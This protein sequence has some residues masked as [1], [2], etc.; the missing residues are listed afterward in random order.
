M[1]CQT[2]PSTI[3]EMADKL[4]AARSENGSYFS[5]GYSFPWQTRTIVV[6]RGTP[7]LVCTTFGAHA[8]LEA[9]DY[10]A[11]RAISTALNEPRTTSAKNFTSRKAQFVPSAIRC[12][13]CPRKFTTPTFLPRRYSL[14]FIATFQMIRCWRKA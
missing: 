1:F 14:V 8:L 3:R 6:P 9:F 11:T 7:N 10:T 5:W 4:I 2:A 12:R 13:H